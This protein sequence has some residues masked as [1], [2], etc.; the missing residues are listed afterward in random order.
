MPLPL[1][2]P[3]KPNIEQLRKQAKDL[4]RSHRSRDSDTCEI[5]RLMHRFADA[6]DDEILESSLTL[7][8]AQ[9][10]LALAYGYGDW[11]DL[12]RYVATTDGEAD[13]SKSRDGEDGSLHVPTV[14]DET[15]ASLVNEIIVDAHAQGASDIHIEP[16]PG[17]N[18]TEI[19]IRIDGDM[20]L[21]RSLEYYLKDPVINR[22]K[23]MANLDLGQRRLPQD[24]KIKLKEFSEHDFEMRVATVP[25]QGGLETVTLRIL[26]SGQPIPLLQMGFTEANY[27]KF[28]GSV[29]RNHGLIL[30]SGPTGS[31]KTTTVHAA[32]HHINVP[33]KKIWT[34]E[35]PVEIT[36]RGLSQ[37]QIDPDRGYDFDVAVRSFLKSD[38]DV[39]MVGELRSK[40][41]CKTCVEASLTGHLVLTTLHTNSSA[42]SLTRL[43]E[44]GIDPFNLSDALLCVLS[45]RLVRT[46]CTSCKKPYHPTKDEYDTLVREYGPAEFERH[47]G[48][49]Y[50]DDLTLSQPEGC[51]RCNG[52]G[53][54]GRMAIHELLIGTDEMKHLI[55]ASARMADIQAQATED[56][57]TTLKQDG[58]DK[59]FMGLCDLMQIRNVLF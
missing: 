50:T 25:T 37:V 6:T 36:Q 43:L 40:Q 48:V 35:D 27:E 15:I 49:P 45:Q 56:G 54:R 32:L 30:V 13:T 24:G 29:E 16:Y 58:I 59:I 8:E 12:Y 28:A 31:G 52:R 21:H 1:V 38:P 41:T 9:F 47:V 57:M 19:R 26:A 18:N 55:R 46:L 7:Q 3:P 22:V 33:E 14:D 23:T 39:I 2:L 20:Y 10:A 42:E 5:L 53:Y 51:D 44:M 4:L 11:N 34:A 17:K